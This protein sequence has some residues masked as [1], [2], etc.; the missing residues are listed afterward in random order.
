MVP[1]PAYDPDAFGTSGFRNGSASLFG[2]YSESM[3]AAQKQV[4]EITLYTTEGDRVTLSLSLQTRAVY[5][6]NEALGYR[7]SPVADPSAAISGERF[8]LLEN[9]SLK[10]AQSRT[11]TL[12]IEGDLSEA[13]LADVTKALAQIDRIM[14][15]QL[16]RQDTLRG[17]RQARKLLGLE[18]IAGIEADYSYET[19]VCTQQATSTQQTVLPGEPPAIPINHAVNRM[20]DLL[21]ASRVD[22]PKFKNPL[23]QLFASMNNAIRSQMG[24][25]HHAARSASNLIDRVQQQLL[26]RILWPASEAPPAKLEASGGPL[27]GD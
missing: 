14:M 24:P 20:V 18:T 22:L 17:V 13:E 21:K 19:G 16:R 27:K 11:M 6:R 1:V 12:S 5:T 3:A 8:A 23:R 26:T 25:D 2:R 15:Q 4:K 9:E 7:K 10:M